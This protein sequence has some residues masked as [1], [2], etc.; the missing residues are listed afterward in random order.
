MLIRLV[1]G[2]ILAPGRPEIKNREVLPPGFG[3]PKQFAENLE[4][5]TS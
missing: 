2:K 5:V 3:V 4:E 1:L